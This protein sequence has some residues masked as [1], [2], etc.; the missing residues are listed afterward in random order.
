MP[1]KKRRVL[2]NKSEANQWITSEVLELRKKRLNLY[3]KKNKNPTENNCNIY[4]E[5]D[6][7]YNKLKRK[8]KNQFYYSGFYRSLNN[9]KDT[10]KL[11]YNVLQTKS[12]KKDEYPETFRSDNKTYTGEPAVSEGFN[13]FF[14]SI[15]AILAEPFN[16]GKNGKNFKKYLK[17]KPQV[18]FI[19]DTLISMTL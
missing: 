7:I 9:A 14:L 18:L 16:K 4:K 15:G 6:K 10:W 17:N 11:I 8:T 3:R 19:L 5:C 1:I 12:S 13:E 2:V